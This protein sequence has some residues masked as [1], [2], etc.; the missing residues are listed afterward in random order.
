MKRK[1]ITSIGLCL[2][3]FATMN[4]N[5]GENQVIEQSVGMA[6]PL[7]ITANSVR[8][9]NWEIHTTLL[10]KAINGDYA[11]SNVSQ[12]KIQKGVDCFYLAACKGYKEAQAKFA[13]VYATNKQ[14]AARSMFLKAAN[15]NVDFGKIALGLLFSNEFPSHTS[16]CWKAGFFVNNFYPINKFNSK[17]MLDFIVSIA[18]SSCW[19]AVN[20]NKEALVNDAKKY[21]ELFSET[22]RSWGLIHYNEYDK[23]ILIVK[24]NQ[25]TLDDVKD[26]SRNNSFEITKS[27]FAAIGKLSNVDVETGISRLNKL[28]YDI[29]KILAID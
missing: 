15:K 17:W 13:L 18:S 5:A 23:K 28:G 2:A 14:N 27:F 10:S 20:K 9:P 8:D 4:V 11:S 3:V 6:S 12:E 21:C 1:I 26:I 25:L 7:P 16:F 22:T 19:S 29:E 24:L